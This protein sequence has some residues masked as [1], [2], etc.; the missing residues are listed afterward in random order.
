MKK[1]YQIDST[2]MF[3]FYKKLMCKLTMFEHFYYKFLSLLSLT[4]V[5]PALNDDLGVILVRLT[6]LICKPYHCENIPFQKAEAAEY[7]EH[8]NQSK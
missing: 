5:F 4:I 7:S 6:R 1:K 8:Q 2:K 3:F